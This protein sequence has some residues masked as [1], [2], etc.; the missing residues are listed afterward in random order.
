[1]ATVQ[2]ETKAAYF[3]VEEA[4]FVSS[5]NARV[6]YLK[7]QEYW[8]YFGRGLVQLTWLF[9]YEKYKKILGVDLVGDPDL[10]L[11]PSFSLFI[12]VHGM[13]T[14]TYTGKPL[15]LYINQNHCDYI[16]ARRVVNGVRKGETLPDR[17]ELIASYAKQWEQF[18]AK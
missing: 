17:S 9:N 15:E 12:L 16:Q 11:E 18:Y 13:L 7:S 3:P 1:M 4:Y 5:T 2:H 14:G 8:P 10:A 6:R